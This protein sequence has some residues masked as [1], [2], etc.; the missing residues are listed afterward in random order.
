M[1]NKSH[2]NGDICSKKKRIKLLLI[3]MF[4]SNIIEIAFALQKY[5]TLNCGVRRKLKQVI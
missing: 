3:K 4:Y 5:K 2:T 1:L